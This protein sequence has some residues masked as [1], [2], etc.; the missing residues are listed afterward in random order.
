MEQYTLIQV[1]DRIPVWSLGLCVAVLGAEVCHM[2][3]GY[4]KGAI[5]EPFSVALKM[6][7]LMFIAGLLFICTSLATLNIV[8]LAPYSQAIASTLATWMFLRFSG[9]I[10]RYV[11]PDKVASAECRPDYSAEPKIILAADQNKAVAAPKPG[12]VEFYERAHRVS[13]DD[14]ITRESAARFSKAVH[15]SSKYGNIVIEF[16]SGGGI[17]HYAQSVYTALRILLQDPECDVRALVTAECSSAALSILMAIPA[18]RRYGS[19]QAHFVIHSAR[20]DRPYSGH[21]ERRKETERINR[22]FVEE[23]LAQGTRIN[24]PKLHELLATWQELHLGPREALELG[25]VSAIID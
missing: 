1:A 21:P 5:F 16:N 20:P 18:D 7:V 8:E 12:F 17:S 14:F 10:M 11:L 23:P 3:W 25:I 19:S 22:D 4:R 2:I 9:R 13:I 6:L 15:K 24:Q